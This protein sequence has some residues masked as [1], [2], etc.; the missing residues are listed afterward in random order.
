[1]YSVV[2]DLRHGARLL[3][4]APAFTVVALVT[5]GLGM[6]A[7]TAIFSVVDAVLLKPLPFRDPARLLV[8]W[9]KNAAQHKF[10]LFVPGANFAE[11]QRQSRT[12]E[13]MAAFRDA[14]LNLTGGPNGRI[15]PEEI[16]V[17]R[18]SAS[19]F[20][21]LG[22]KVALGRVFRDEEDQPD[23]GNYALLSHRL[24]ER[25]FASDPGILGK[26]ILVS[27]R[28]LTVVG[29]FQPGFFVMDPTVD[30]WMPL[31]LNPNDLV[32]RNRFLTVIA[33]MRPGVSFAQARS[34]MDVLGDNLEKSNPSLNTGWRPSLFLLE[35]ELLGSVRRTLTILMGAVGF[36][37]LM[38]C[39]NVANLLLT[40]GA[41]RRKEIAIRTALGAT[42]GRIVIQMLAESIKLALAGGTLGILL[43]RGGIALLQRLGPQSIPRMD[44]ARLDL[45]L[46]LFVFVVSLATGA[47]F[48]IAPVIQLS[49]AHVST[50][51]GE[52]GRGGTVGRRGGMARN[53]LVIAEVALA[54]VVLIG[55]GLLIRSFIRLRTADA[56]F[57]PSGVL[58]FRL[59]LAGTRNAATERRVAFVQQVIDRLGALPGV[60]SAAAVSTL[61]LTGLWDGQPF[62][63]EGRPM[64]SPD[65]QPIALTRG[66]TPSYFGA[67]G[68]PLISGRT[69][70]GADTV[71][72][73]RV[74]VVNQP[75]A[76]LLWPNQEAVG[77]RLLMAAGRTIE[78]VGVVADVKQDQIEGEPRPTIYAPY[79]QAPYTTMSIVVKVAGEPLSLASAVAREVHQMDPDQ[80][81]TDVRTME[82]VVGRAVA[83][84]RFNAVLLGVFGVIAFV[85]AS[86]GIYG[87]IA[88]VVTERTHEI[89]I[90]VALG[91]QSGDVLKLVV[92]H[93]AR[94]A[95]WGIALGLAAA[96][97][98]TRLM[99]SMLYSVK[100]TDGF[101]FA[102]ISL[103]LGAVAVAASYLPSRRA[104]ALDP[105]AALRHE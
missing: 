12:F 22:A 36:L 41:I 49:G 95:A 76:R 15:D 26:A 78:I 57:Q 7:S 42:R 10:K 33:R 55:A 47:L 105:V 70:T 2:R 94:L 14:F 58:T 34:E 11:W 46:F 5:L 75:L 62:W 91:A 24:W 87:V 74:F 60:R 20:P 88:C 85:L 44:E 17:E 28:S 45:R 66:V 53:A 80:P 56:G 101:T 18:V 102:L 51:L 59:S 19:M 21:M 90:R 61:P 81:V 39:A 77:K 67:M 86:V 71:Q 97:A 72:A 73:P 40:R 23:R 82:S 16:R 100:A 64:P 6:G 104:M 4:N 52:G 37:L 32:G 30:L 13:S 27:G 96:L 1:M 54:V 69:F 93:G 35:D 92:G 83:G 84:A 68:I 9:E 38:A 25:R 8:V 50:A 3:W 99:S 79:P 65:Q 29:V 31:A 98:L 103:L 63:V 43:A 89:G 48:G